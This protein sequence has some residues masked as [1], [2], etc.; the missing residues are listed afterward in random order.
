M[1]R[2]IPEEHSHKLCAT[3]TTRTFLDNKCLVS[4]AQVTLQVHAEKNVPRSLPKAVVS[5]ILK[6]RPLR[7]VW[8]DK[9]S[10]RGFK[11]IIVVH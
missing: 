5:K 2:H 8:F 9:V 10:H 1:L 11:N 4:H 3:K 6:F 7:Q